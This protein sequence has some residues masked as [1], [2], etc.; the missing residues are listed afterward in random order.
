[1]IRKFMVDNN[2]EDESTAIGREIMPLIE[3]VASAT[4]RYD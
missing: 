2:I 4:H 1:M 3:S